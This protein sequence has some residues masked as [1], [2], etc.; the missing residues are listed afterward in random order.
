MLQAAQALHTTPTPK[1]V[2][3]DSSSQTSDALLHSSHSDRT[4]QVG[5]TLLGITRPTTQNKRKSAD[6]KDAGIQCARA[7]TSTLQR[8]DVTSQ[9]GDD[10]DGGTDIDGGAS[11]VTMQQ[12]LLSIVRDATHTSPQRHHTDNV[13]RKLQSFKMSMTHSQATLSLVI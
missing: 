11:A 12:E 3:I 8:P 7:D 9:S 4:I 1:P 6:T 2:T 10:V 13:V 5:D